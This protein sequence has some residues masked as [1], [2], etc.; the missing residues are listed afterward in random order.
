MVSFRSVDCSVDQ[1]WAA[2]LAGEE[3]EWQH[4]SERYWV[5][6]KQVAVELQ[7]GLGTFEHSS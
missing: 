1:D 5:V 3:G 7:L 4:E 2:R 6:E